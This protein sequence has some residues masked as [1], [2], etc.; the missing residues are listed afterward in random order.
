M[1]KGLP[2]KTSEMD[3]VLKIKVVRQIRVS[4]GILRQFKISFE[5]PPPSFLV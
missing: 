5:F 1:I 3:E 2:M 4:L